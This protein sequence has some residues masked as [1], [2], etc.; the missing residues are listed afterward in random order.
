ME[1]AQTV[2]NVSYVRD[3]GF[4]KDIKAFVIALYMQ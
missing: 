4:L 3:T 2:F 1:G